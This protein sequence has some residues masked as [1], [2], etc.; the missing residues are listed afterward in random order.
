M[1]IAFL[2]DLSALAILIVILALVRRRHSEARADAWLL[3]LSFT[4]IESMAHTFYAPQG[5]PGQGAAP[6]RAGL[7]CAG[8][9][10]VQLGGRG[11]RAMQRSSR[12]LYLV[13]NGTDAAGGDQHLRLERP[14]FA[15]LYSRDCDRHDRRRGQ[16]DLCAPQLAVRAAV[17][18]RVERDRVAGQPRHVP[19]GSLL[20]P[21]V[22]VCDCGAELPAAAGA[23]RARAGWR[24]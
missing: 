7:L 6:D 20:E 4:L 5:M 15:R 21:G 3:G 16:F 19:A 11:R 18:V 22:R 12:L 23:A 10:G 9:A 17:P 1:N 24:S 13:L 2:P 14:G 8:G